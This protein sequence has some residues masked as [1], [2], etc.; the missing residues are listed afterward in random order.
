MPIWRPNFNPDHLYFVTTKAVDYTHLFQRDIVKRLLV[1]S[2]D[3]LRLRQWFT[4]YAFVI[5]TNHIH[6]IIQC[7]AERPLETIIRDF[8]KHV[9]DRLRRQYQLEM[10]QKA[11]EFLAS[12]AA[13]KQKYKVWETGY[14]A[15]DIFSP[16]FLHQKLTY[17]HNNPCQP[18]WQ[19]AERPEDY[20][21]SS[22]P[23]YLTE[24]AALIPVT[25]VRP[26]MV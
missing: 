2:L 25:D 26:L 10:N 20:I 3:C 23:F 19:L 16:D 9:T 17:L 14:Q 5:M 7:A 22:A 12:K 21:W 11:L 18:H 1:D 15:K 6:L 13:G 8:K 24:Q 4:L